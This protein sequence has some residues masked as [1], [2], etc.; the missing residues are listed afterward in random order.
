M[1]RLNFKIAPV[2]YGCL[3]NRVE[4]GGLLTE[5]EHWQRHFMLL[6]CPL[7]TDLNVEFL[8]GVLMIKSLEG[9]LLLGA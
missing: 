9:D 4:E 3:N 6:D 5:M 1:C 8:L 7:K 2:T